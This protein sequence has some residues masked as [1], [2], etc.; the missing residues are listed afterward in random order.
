MSSFTFSQSL[1][2]LA[3][4][5]KRNCFP[6]SLTVMIF[7]FAA[8]L[9]LE[10]DTLRFQP[11]WWLASIEKTSAILLGGTVTRRRSR[12]KLNR[13]SLCCENSRTLFLRKRC[14]ALTSE[15]ETN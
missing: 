13:A 15:R 5:L 2:S 1:C 4:S 7:Y 14:A 11:H 8:A 6:F 12:D 3:G 10:R 9:S